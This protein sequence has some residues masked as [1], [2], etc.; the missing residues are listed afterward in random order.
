MQMVRRELLPLAMVGT[1]QQ[2]ID[3]IDEIYSLTSAPLRVEQAAQ[4]SAM[5]KHALGLFR[6]KDAPMLWGTLAGRLSETLRRSTTGNRGDN[7]EEAI[8]ISEAVLMELS[9]HQ[10]PIRLAIA[11]LNL[12]V[13]FGDRGRGIAAENRRK[14]IALLDRARHV[15]RPRLFPQYCVVA[16]NDAAI[17]YFKGDPA[18]RAE[19]TEAAIAALLEGISVITPE[20]DPVHWGDLHQHLGIAYH[21]RVDGDTAENIERSIAAYHQA[22]R[23]RTKTASPH[24]WVLTQMD[25]GNALLV[26]VRG[27]PAENVEQA[28]HA[29]AVA[30]EFSQQMGYAFDW[31][32]L[33]YDLCNAYL[34]RL[35]GDRA[36]NSKKSIHA[37]SS[38][39]HEITLE[40]HP[41][42]WGNI[43]QNLGNAYRELSRHED[44][45]YLDL[46]IEAYEKALSV[47]SPAKSRADWLATIDDLSGAYAERGG[48]DD[49]VER[50]QGLMDEAVRIG[51]EGVP[52]RL[53]AQF[54]V[55]LGTAYRERKSG[56]SAANQ[57]RAVEAFRQG[58]DVAARFGLYE[59]LRRG[60]LRL[61]LLRGQSG[62]WEQAYRELT[63]VATQ[64]E[65]VYDAA[66]TVEGKEKTADS[67]WFFYQ[68]LVET[69]LRTS[70]LR[71][72][73]LHAEEGNSRSLRDELAR[74]PLPAPGVPGDLVD[75]EAA[76]LERLRSI[77]LTLRR[78]DE[79]EPRAQLA[80]EFH[81]VRER[82]SAIWR[83]ME[84]Q[85][86]AHAYVQLRRGE[87]LVWEQL[88][89]WLSKQ[90]K[91]TALIEFSD[92]AD[93]WVAFVVR[94]NDSEPC[95]VEIDLPQ[96]LLLDLV[97]DYAS[98][99]H[100]GNDVPDSAAD[101]LAERLLAPLAAHLSD[102]S[103][104][105]L[106]PQGLLHYVP[107]HALA[108]QGRPL[109]ES[110]VVHY[111]PSAAAAIRGR[112]GEWPGLRSG[113][114]VV[115][116]NP[117]GDLPFA[118]LE[119]SSVAR[120]FS[121]SALVG[122]GASAPRVVGEL[123]H[124]D[125]AHVAA[126]AWFDQRDPL[127]SGILLSGGTV[128]NAREAMNQ[129]LRLRLP[130]PQRL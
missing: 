22:L 128:L 12:A 45:K 23:T 67:N 21:R 30:A 6:R 41:D 43:Q 5:I 130:C 8:R 55:N 17:Q 99:L 113:D 33:Q 107:V 3:A 87:R 124:A 56:N 57:I 106:I 49:D 108:Y 102:I 93:R 94:A 27:D 71:E 60:V 75:E 29:Y 61:A 15:F 114:V 38:A 51:S 69:C 62:E 74:L 34:R 112:R 110:V 80:D 104:V 126:H 117:T 96:Q 129:Q 115:V 14:A 122:E 77:D 20:R 47:R 97:T 35:H 89:N 92:L 13:L 2:I 4:R 53:W 52:P 65:Q 119:A 9:T 10:E 72:A 127:A 46:S 78:T 101:E 73:F 40:S 70:R 120:R 36:E 123:A 84:R 48:R 76:L 50:L 32:R 66:V 121:C 68:R 64:L 7:L 88:Q 91:P 109:V 58:I 25:L 125:A 98:A 11:E 26:R 28:I 59:V 100:E 31:A 79:M 18:A 39:L 116:G 103:I 24:N 95:V 44:P 42:D 19:D 37:G 85:P 105:C 1:D 54:L 16:S 83:E 90:P 82:L 63:E 111:A 81:T 118:E 86:E